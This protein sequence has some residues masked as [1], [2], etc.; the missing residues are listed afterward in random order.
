MTIATGMHHADGVAT[1]AKPA[2][3]RVRGAAARSLHAMIAAQ[4]WSL[5]LDQVAAVMRVEDERITAP[6]LTDALARLD[7]PYSTSDIGA[8]DLDRGPYPRLIVLPD[9]AA[10][11]AEGFHRDLGVKVT[12]PGTER[13]GWI[14]VPGPAAVEL[15]IDPAD[16][17]A[18]QPAPPSMRKVIGEFLPS[19]RPLIVTSMLVNLL[20]LATPIFVMTIYDTALPAR[21]TDAIVALGIGLM[22]AYVTEIGMRRLRGQAVVHLASEVETRIAPWMLRKTVSMPPAALAQTDPYR[23]QAKLR[24]S[25]GIRSALSGQ[26]IQAVL[27]LPFLLLFVAVIFLIAPAIGWLLVACAAI[28]LTTFAAVAPFLKERDTATAVAQDAHRKRLQHAIDR[29]DTIRRHGLV[30]G[31][32]DH[33]RAGLREVIDADARAESLRQGI[34]VCLQALLILTGLTSGYVATRM[35]VNGDLPMGQLVAILILVWRFL[36]PVQTLTTASQQAVSLVEGVRAVEALLS[37]PEETYRGTSAIAAIDIAPPLR[38]DQVTLRFPQASMPALLGVSFEVQRG[39]VVVVSG[40]VMAG[41]SCVAELVAALHQPS[42]GR[43]LIGGRVVRQLPVDDL[44][45]RIAFCPQGLQ[46]FRATIRQ[47]LQFAAPLV[48]EEDLWTALEEAGAADE[49]ARLPQGLS[50]PI[51]TPGRAVLSDHLLKEI[52]LAMTFLRP[53]PLYVF[54]DPTQGLDGPS[55]DRV[56]AAIRKRAERGA[57]LM[58]SNDPFDLAIGDRFVVLHHGRVVSNERGQRGRNRA[59]ALLNPRGASA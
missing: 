12:V 20:G 29:R 26:L 47:N 14:G 34:G 24:Q 40:R 17:Q 25:E 6:D 41:K 13:A 48:T 53:G 21:S 45:A 58:I 38:F 49:I 3:G 52:S 57:V 30:S 33:L 32:E 2:Q 39:Q 1:S 28:S 18:A 4:G 19:L 37:Q 50:T 46:T 8:S 59:L 36:G 11:F 56:R 5:S 22:I 10:H 55:S 44:R 51:D 27:D 43:V 35:A 42:A 54:D 9:G 23:Q 16:P 15:K 7:L 31:T